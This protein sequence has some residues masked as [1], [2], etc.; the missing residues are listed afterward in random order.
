PP[1]IDGRDVLADPGRVLRLLCE[2][3]G[4]SFTDRMLA[5]SPGI[6]TTDGVWARHWYDSV[7]KS[8]GFERPQESE[9]SAE[10]DVDADLRAYAPIL[11]ESALHYARMGRY[12]LR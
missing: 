8:S 9:P 1:V 7:S 10:V 11:R 6:R 12:A 4:L 2:R 3:L 5:W